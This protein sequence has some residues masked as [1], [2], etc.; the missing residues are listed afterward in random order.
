MPQRR[1]QNVL[2]VMTY[3]VPMKIMEYASIFQKL[4]KMKKSIIICFD[5]D[6]WKKFKYLFRWKLF[7]FLFWLLN[8]FCRIMVEQNLP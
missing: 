4:E 8:D 6:L 5:V 1:K 2:L 7:V 3:L